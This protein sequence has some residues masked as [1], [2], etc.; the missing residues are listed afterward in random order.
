M[1]NIFQQHF[2]AGDV[3]K[4]ADISM[5]TL[6]NWIKRD[7]IVGHKK[8]EGGGSQ[9][10]H[11][12]F[13]WHNVIEIATAAALVKV[14]VTD[15]SIAFRAAQL[16]AHTGAGPLPGKPGRCPGLPF[17]ASNVR[18][19]LF[20][21]GEHSQILPYSPNKGGEDVLAVARIGLRKP[22]AF[23]VVDLLE[24]FDR[25][26]GALGLHPQEVMDRAYSKTH[27]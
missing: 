8:I 22:E 3:T 10:R 15:L 21:S 18:T 9:G 6:Q 16:F 7:V 2:S 4:A 11:R 5:S 27:G 23:I 20:V 24:L 1:I 25:V 14:G 12:R 19:L 17:E 26:C 13:S